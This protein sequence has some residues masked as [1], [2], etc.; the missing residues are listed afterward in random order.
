MVTNPKKEEM[1]CRQFIDRLIYSIPTEGM[2]YNTI[3][4]S[5]LLSFPVSTS[6][7]KRF[8]KE[9]YIDDNKIE[10]I[11]GIVYVKK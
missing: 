10:L 5:T 6:M 7:V 3:I 4:R 2:S 1:K 8:I 11:E 9:G